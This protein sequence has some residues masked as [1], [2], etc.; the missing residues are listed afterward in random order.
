MG[1]ILKLATDVDFTT[2]SERLFQT[3]DEALETSVMECMD[4]G[5]APLSD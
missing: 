4:N 1:L 2:V 3:Y 5:S